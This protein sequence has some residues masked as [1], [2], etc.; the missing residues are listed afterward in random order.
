MLVK[1]T[2]LILLFFANILSAT[3]QQKAFNPSI[4]AS[5]IYK[6]FQSFRDSTG[7]YSSSKAEVGFRVPLIRKY[8]KENSNLFALMFSAHGSQLNISS[9]VFPDEE[10]IYGAAAGLSM[11]YRF[12]KK[13][14]LLV[15]L[16]SSFA[17]DAGNISTPVLRTAGSIIYVRKPTE[18]FSLIIG[19]AG[20]ANYNNFRA[21]PILGM[22]VRTGKRSSLSMILP[23]RFNFQYRPVKKLGF[24]VSFSP[25]GDQMRFTGSDSLS[26]INYLKLRHL[27]LSLTVRYFP[28]KYFSIYVQGGMMALGRFTASNEVSSVRYRV[29][30]G[31]YIKAGISFRF[32]GRKK[33]SQDPAT[34]EQSS[35]EEDVILDELN[36]DDL[37][38]Y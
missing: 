25:S 38:N 5:N 35:D 6:P 26:S 9:S 13:N 14:N 18:N 31:P 2:I 34:A 36:T 33:A 32:G 29:D 12:K 7:G 11:F 21:L 24:N 3:A 30:P 1:K 8:N 22:K 19:F 37:L 20:A 4:Q 15:S 23:L 10:K 28:V 17:E 16:R 27:D